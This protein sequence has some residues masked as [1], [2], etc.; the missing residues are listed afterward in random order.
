MFLSYEKQNT[1][2]L[3]FTAQISIKILVYNDTKNNKIS[4][5]CDFILGLKY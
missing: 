2:L 4:I 3:K 5:V 1:I